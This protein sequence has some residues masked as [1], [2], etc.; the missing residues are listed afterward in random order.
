MADIADLL[1]NILDDPDTSEKLR[2]LMGQGSSS[3]SAPKQI[4]DIDPAMLAK[5]TKALSRV[6]G[7]RDDSRTRLLY[8][9]KPYVSDARRARVDKAIEMLKMLWIIEIL[10]DEKE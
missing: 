10:K 2:S 3:L 7:A 5:V 1:K 9:L 6:S 4:A 8:D